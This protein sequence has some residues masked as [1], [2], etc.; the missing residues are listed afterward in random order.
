MPFLPGASFI[1]NPSSVSRGL[2]KA[3]VIPLDNGMTQC[4]E[5]LQK[6]AYVTKQDQQLI[7]WFKLEIIMRDVTQLLGLS[8]RDTPADIADIR[9]QCTI[10]AFEERLGCWKKELSP[11]I[12]HRMCAGQLVR[13]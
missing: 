4:I 13:V 5:A 11:G 2:R 7:A 9:T 3:N 6:S 8:D 1:K 12:M 10:K